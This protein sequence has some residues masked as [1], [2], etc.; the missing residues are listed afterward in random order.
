MAQIEIGTEN[1]GYAIA[2]E[3]QN[4]KNSDEIIDPVP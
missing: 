4:I 1:K 3:L 2:K